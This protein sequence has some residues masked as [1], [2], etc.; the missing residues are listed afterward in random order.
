[1]NKFYE[2]KPTNET[3]WR[4][5]IL[6]GRN[7]ATYKFALGKALLELSDQ[8]KTFIRLEELADPFSRYICEHL[9]LSDKQGTFSK[10]KFL[11]AC[12]KYNS[13]ILKKE[14]L[15]QETVA[16][17]FQNVI[18]AFHVVNQ[19]EIS[20]RFY[21]DE[22]KQRKGI[23]ITDE[24]LALKKQLQFLNLP[25]EVD[26]RWRLVETA[27][28]IGISTNLL[29]VKYDPDKNL[30][31]S[32]NSLSRRINIASS[33]DSLNGYQKGKCFYCA[34]DILIDNFNPGFMSDVD[35]FFPFI[36][37][38]RLSSININGVWNLVLSCMECNRGRDGK[39]ARVPEHSFL[40]KLFD[41]NEYLIS[42]HHP[43]RETI[44]NQTGVTVDERRDFLQ[45]VDNSA[46]DYLIH[47]WRPLHQ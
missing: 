12:R 14:D 38:T 11:D 19:G 17:G 32:E 18:D 3:L 21:I 27:W 28:S 10:S 1:M 22:R 7:V 6:F 25:F 44:I 24:L 31:F 43:L 42:S 41:R 5:V 34:R 39:L 46:I 30:F 29:E 35:H 2:K 23:N 26:A 36:L 15:I 9:K 4:S 20:K 8:E 45:K 37:T 40:E 13:G 47:R 33:R 16:R